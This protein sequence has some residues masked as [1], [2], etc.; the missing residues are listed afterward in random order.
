MSMQY[1]WNKCLKKLRGSAIINSN[2]SKKSKISSG[3]DVIETSMSHYSYCGYNCTL[4]YCDI[5]SFCSLADDVSIGLSSHPIDWV[6]TSPIFY[7]QKNILKKNLTN[8]SYQ[9]VKKTVIGHD[10][11]IGKGVKVK[12]GIKIGNGAIIGMGSVV[13]KDI[14]DYGIYAG[15]PAK[16]VKMRFSD[17]IVQQLLDL[18]WWN[19]S[20]E[21]LIKAAQFIQD[22]IQFIK[23]CNEDRQGIIK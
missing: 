1:I 7:K 19:L 20:E 5:G 10:V 18:Q 4:I 6:S 8:Y 23:I 21:T 13:T 17:E 3:C 22:P 14:V 12:S 9:A 16:L 15:V 2:I 11:W